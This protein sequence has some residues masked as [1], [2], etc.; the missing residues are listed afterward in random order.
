MEEFSGHV[1]RMHADRDK[2]FEMEYNVSYT[3]THTTYMFTRYLYK[4]T[5]Q[6]HQCM[7]VHPH[8]SIWPRN[9]DLLLACFEVLFCWLANRELAFRLNPKHVYRLEFLVNSEQE[10]TFMC[11]SK[12]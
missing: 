12:L 6:K 3:H 4:V 2:Q 9:Y 7:Y 5:T 8:I 1:Q 11:L 10:Q